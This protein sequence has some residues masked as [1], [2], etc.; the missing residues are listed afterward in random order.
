MQ[1][2][3]DDLIWRVDESSWFVTLFY[4]ILPYFC[5]AQVNW[6]FFQFWP[7]F[8]QFCTCFDACLDA[9]VAPNRDRLCVP[10]QNLPSAGGL[11]PHSGPG[12]CC[13]DKFT[14]EGIEIGSTEELQFMRGTAM[15]TRDFTYEPAAVLVGFHPIRCDSRSSAM[16]Q[17]LHGR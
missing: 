9:N 17:P 12:L 14:V 6:I 11:M 13:N 16:V 1:Q 8:P 15:I 7:D 4:E 5:F 2:L 3:L 10:L